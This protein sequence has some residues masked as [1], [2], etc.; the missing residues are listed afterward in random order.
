MGNTTLKG[1]TT[2]GTSISSTTSEESLTCRSRRIYSTA[3]TY[4][5]PTGT[6]GDELLSVTTTDQTMTA[7]SMSITGTLDAKNAVIDSVD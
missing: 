4:I 1:T 6:E 3:F 5:P 7:K 2:I